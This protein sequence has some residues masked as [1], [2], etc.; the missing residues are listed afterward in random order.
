MLI[1]ISAVSSFVLYSYTY[2]LVYVAKQNFIRK[3][4]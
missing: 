2:I 3:P 4:S 1:D